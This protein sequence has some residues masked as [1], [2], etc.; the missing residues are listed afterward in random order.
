MIIGEGG[1]S[2]GNIF[3]NADDCGFYEPISSY[4]A[5]LSQAVSNYFTQTNTTTTDALQSAI[6]ENS[7]FLTGSSGDSSLQLATLSPDD[8][9]ARLNNTRG[10]SYTG[11]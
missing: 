10:L 5:D 4:P 9:Y 7:E 11:T 3:T 2:D 1:G 6:G 8:S